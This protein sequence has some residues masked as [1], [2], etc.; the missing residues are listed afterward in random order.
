M[1]GYVV[2]LGETMGLLSTSEA[3]THAA[4][5]RLGIGGAESNVAIALRR[6]GVDAVWVGR[7][8]ADSLGDLVERELRAEGVSTR[9]ITDPDAPTGLMLKE[10][11]S[12]RS[13]NVWYYRRESAGSR[14]EPDDIPDGLIESAA[15]VHVTGITPALSP[16]AHAAVAAAVGRSLAAGVPV[17]FDINYRAQ[18]W[19]GRDIRAALLPLVSAC[20]VVFGGLDELQLIAEGL[21]PLDVARAIASWGPRQVV[22]KLGDQGCF[23]LVDD[24][25]Y[26]VPARPATVID[27]VGAGDAFV[28]AYLSQLVIGA[29]ARDRLDAAVLAGA[30]ACESSGD[31]E[32][33]PRLADLARADGIE[34]VS[35]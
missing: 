11:R 34:A 28:A 10:R 6:L 19:R 23:A 26:E 4:G 5:G 22:V 15:L 27:T 3:L 13:T 32:G 17:S 24:E 33:A 14:L 9:I 21:R 18:L 30:L 1:T 12:S 7:R 8:G 2:T 29:P 16:S 35:R 25:T 31:W 20:T